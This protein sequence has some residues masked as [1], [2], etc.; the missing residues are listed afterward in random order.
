MLRRGV[1]DS[2]TIILRTDIYVQRFWCL[3]EAAWA[4]EFGVPTVVADARQSLTSPREVLPIIDLA[5]VRVPDGNLIRILNSALRE[6]VRLRRF[7]CSVQLLEQT[8]ALPTGRALAVPRVSLS[9]LGVA[10]EERKRTTNGV[11]YVIFPERF[12]E[13]LRP[14]A[15]RLVKAYFPKA[16]LGIPSDFV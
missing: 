2:I 12:R 13:A 11:D 7:Q 14:I 8:E 10:C 4:E 5:S 9:S 3:Q 15:E 16:V 6:A 1:Q